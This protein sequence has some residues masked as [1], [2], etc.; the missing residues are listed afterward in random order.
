VWEV[1]TGVKVY[2]YEVD[3]LGNKLTDFDDPNSERGWAGRAGLGWDG[4]GWAGWCKL[5]PGFGYFCVGLGVPAPACACLR[6]PAPACWPILRGAANGLPACGRRQLA[7]GCVRALAA[8]DC[9]WGPA[10]LC[11]VD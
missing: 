6:L 10:V 7:V 4:L 9:C 1:E 3:G 2:A 11:P 5:L 8:D